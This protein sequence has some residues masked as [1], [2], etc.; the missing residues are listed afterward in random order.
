MTFNDVNFDYNQ[1]L[2]GFLRPSMMKYET[3][4]IIERISN[5]LYNS[6]DAIDDEKTE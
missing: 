1:K 5:E 6:K 4:L 3:I 2:I